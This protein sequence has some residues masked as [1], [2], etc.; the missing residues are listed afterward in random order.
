M[1]YLEHQ[2]MLKLL[3]HNASRLHSKYQEVVSEDKPIKLDFQASFVLPFCSIGMR[4]LGSL[5]KDQGC[6]LCGKKN[7]RRCAQCLA[8]S[9]CSR[10]KFFFS[11]PFVREL[12]IYIPSYPIRRMSERGL[13]K[14]QSNLP[15]PQRRYLAYNFSK[16]TS[17][18][19][20]IPPA[21]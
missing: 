10:G 3:H 8:V 5:T 14:P 1:S 18:H 16:R 13:E 4:D 17:W 9:Y 11:D 2:A 7:I 19:A 21:C 6:Q 12:S 20:S 15:F